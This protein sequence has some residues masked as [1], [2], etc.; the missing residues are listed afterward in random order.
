MFFLIVLGLIFCMQ[1]LKLDNTLLILLLILKINFKLLLRFFYRQWTRIGYERFFLSSKGIIHQTTCVETPEQ[2][3]M[4]ERKHQNLLNVTRALIFLA[5]L[6]L[7]FW[8]FFVQHAT[9]LINCT[10]TPL[11]QNIALYEKFHGKSCDLSILCV[12]GC[13]CYS[14][15]LTAHRK[16]IR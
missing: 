12:F 7:L 2:N 6:P 15:T 13:L 10:P 14:S 5:H 3:G 1:N 8:D 11:L 16:K 4:I 9:F